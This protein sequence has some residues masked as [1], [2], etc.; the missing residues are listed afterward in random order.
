VIR[1][2]IH[3]HGIG[4]L[5]LNTIAREYLLV[6][7]RLTDLV[8]GS[9]SSSQRRQAPILFEVRDRASVLNLQCNLVVT[10]VGITGSN[11]ISRLYL[12]QIFLALLDTLWEIVLINLL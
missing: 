7:K 3:G 10:I 9:W 1:N 2:F 12:R 4:S 5:N 6:T 11:L 8:I